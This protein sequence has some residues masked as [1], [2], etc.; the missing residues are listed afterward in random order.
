MDFRAE[1]DSQ[2]SKQA[3]SIK[4]MSPTDHRAS[5]H[6]YCSTDNF[7]M[8]PI[9]PFRCLHLAQYNDEILTFLTAQVGANRRGEECSLASGTSKR[10]NE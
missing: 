6:L 2:C 3:I 4:S 10:D 8:N 5:E 1:T 9:S 7:Q